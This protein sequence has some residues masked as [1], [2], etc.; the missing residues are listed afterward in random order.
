MN[1]SQRAKIVLKI[2][3]KT[4]ALLGEVQKINEDPET[5]GPHQLFNTIR[6]SSK[7]VREQMNSTYQDPYPDKDVE[8]CQFLPLPKS[9]YQQGDS[10]DGELSNL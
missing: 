7:Y 3:N 2:L 4:P 1:E 9:D 6:Y 10:K 5:T 8:L